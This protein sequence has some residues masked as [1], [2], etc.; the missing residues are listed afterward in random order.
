MIEKHLQK[1]LL[2]RR[3]KFMIPASLVATVNVNN[4][5][6][7]AFLVLRRIGTPKLSLLTMKT[8]IVVNYL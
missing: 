1:L 6:D 5:L 4:S 2:Q 3:G 8:I 7:H